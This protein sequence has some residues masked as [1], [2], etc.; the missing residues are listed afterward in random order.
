[1]PLFS[2]CS[3]AVLKDS[4]ECVLLQ[5][6]AGL[7]SNAPVRPL[8]RG[9]TRHSSRAWVKESNARTEGDRFR[10]ITACLRTPGDLS[11]SA[12]ACGLGNHIALV[13][14]G[15]METSSSPDPYDPDTSDLC[16]CLVEAGSVVSLV[17][18][19]KIRD[20]DDDTSDA[21]SDAWPIKRGNTCFLLDPNL[22]IL[23]R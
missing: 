21:L 7:E 18:E 20:T 4:R 13:V 17:A 15:L 22:L 14:S 16:S 23:F 11:E 12:L 19:S 10:S 2:L 6:E 8:I 3:S 1:M 9:G 5:G